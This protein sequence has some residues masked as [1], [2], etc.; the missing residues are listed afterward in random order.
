MPHREVAGEMDGL[1]VLKGNDR[2][3][4][5]A[6]RRKVRQTLGPEILSMKLFGSKVRGSDQPG[7]DIDV[8][9]VVSART[10]A[11]VDRIINLAFEVNLAFDVY[12]SPRVVGQNALSDPRWA[13]TPLIQAV[14]RDSPYSPWP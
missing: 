14:R 1:N 2:S 11:L 7:S 8:L 12:I 3:A 4:V 13:V 9:V 10:P 6:F 5:E